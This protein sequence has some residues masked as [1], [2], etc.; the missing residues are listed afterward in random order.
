MP[1]IFES[2]SRSSK[3]C[4]WR[5]RTLRQPPHHTGDSG[6]GQGVGRQASERDPSPRCATRG[7][8]LGSL[9]TVAL[10]AVMRQQIDA[11]DK[12]GQGGRR[13]GALI[14]AV[15]KG[16]IEARAVL[17]CAGKI[18]GP[19]QMGVVTPLGGGDG[20][21]CRARGAHRHLERPLRCGLQT[22]LASRGATPARRRDQA[23][24]APTMVA[25]EGQFELAR[26]QTSLA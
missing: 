25:E 16:A 1:R 3:D 6:R 4:T 2:S 9:P 26:E 17:T 18:C 24:R 20:L 22:I 21:F 12:L 10:A 15:G 11:V 7:R 14:C 5:R 13:C 19:R 23:G 8:R